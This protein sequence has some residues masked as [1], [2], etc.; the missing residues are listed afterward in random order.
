V[1][2]GPL[3]QLVKRQLTRA[4]YPPGHRAPARGR[5]QRGNWVDKVPLRPHERRVVNW[6]ADQR[7]V[8]PRR[9]PGPPEPPTPGDDNEDDRTVG[10]GDGTP[11]PAPV[12]DDIEPH[13]L[14]EDDQPGG[15]RTAAGP[16]D[17][18]NRGPV[19]GP[20]WGGDKSEESGGPVSGPASGPSG[21]PRPPAPPGAKIPGAGGAAAGEAGAAGAAGEAAGGAAIA[22]EAAE[23][24]P[25]L[26][27]A[28]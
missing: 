18:G 23:L 19:Q 10:S 12:P 9:P 22:G 6:F 20:D 21:G 27:A 17:F 3:T 5:D 7:Q 11:T 16:L 1:T 24:A 28:V 4:I 13:D 25:L 14:N 15:R 26:L 2:D 8:D